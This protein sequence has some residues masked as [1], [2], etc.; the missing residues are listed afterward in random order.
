MNRLY[1]FDA[2]AVLDFVDG[3]AGSRKVEVLLNEA[4]AQRALLLMSVVNYGEVFYQLWQRRG[5]QVA[6]ETV[7]KLIRLGIECV[8][9]QLDQVLAGGEIKVLH[10][11]PYTD[12][13]AAA[14][15]IIRNGLL[16]TADRDFEKLG[17]RVRVVW[18]SR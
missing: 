2:S 8:P 1:V 16:V 18:I 3:G 10:K 9:V 12:C 4:V 7:S 17:R 13:L 6:R 14:L 11:I 15:A 5:E